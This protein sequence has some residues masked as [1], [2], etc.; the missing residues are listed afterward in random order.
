MACRCTYQESCHDD[1]TLQF[2]GPASEIRLWHC[3][4]QVEAGAAAERPG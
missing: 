2:N 1:K 3:L 4:I